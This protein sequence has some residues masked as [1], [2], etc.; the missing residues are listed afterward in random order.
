MPFTDQVAE[1]EVSF[2]TRVEVPFKV[3]C[4]ESTTVIVKAPF[5]RPNDELAMTTRVPVV[6]LCAPAVVTEMSVKPLPTMPPAAETLPLALVN[7]PPVRGVTTQVPLMFSA[8]GAPVIEICTPA[9]SLF[10]ALVIMAGE[11]ENS[12]MEANE[13][14]LAND[15]LERARIRLEE[16]LGR[17]TEQLAATRRDL[18][19]V[20]AE[21]RSHFGYAGL[22]GTSAAM[23]KL[24]AILERVKDTDVPVLITGESGTGKEVVA[25][26][27]HQ[28][29]PR[30]K[31]AQIESAAQHRPLVVDRV[32]AAKIVPEAE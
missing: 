32:D 13:L 8:A 29:S 5:A 10:P 9:A 1:P 22:V 20:R 28:A 30:A 2:P 15:E 3:K 16:A 26:A 18:R 17:R 12:W 4:V 31:N 6:K 21:L 14:A 24:Y 11:V 19:Q 27:I 25:R 23:R 7:T